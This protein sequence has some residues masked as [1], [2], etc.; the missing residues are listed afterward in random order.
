LPGAAADAASDVVE[1]APAVDVGAR[2][3]ATRASETHSRF[4]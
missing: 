4:T 2:S 3:A 1:I